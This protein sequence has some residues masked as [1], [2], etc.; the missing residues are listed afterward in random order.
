MILCEKCK[1]WEKF[2]F[3]N[4]GYCHKIKLPGCT[5]VIKKNNDNTDNYNILTK[6]NFGCNAGKNKN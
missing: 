6:G 5:V 2:H 1:F 4:Y 3:D